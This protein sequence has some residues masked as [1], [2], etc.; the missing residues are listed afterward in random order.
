MSLKQKINPIK[1]KQWF[2][3]LPIAWKITGWYSIFLFLMLILLANFTINFISVLDTAETSADLKKKT[4]EAAAEVDTFSSLQDNY[5]FILYEESGLFQRGSFPIDFPIHAPLSINEISTITVKGKDFYYT[6]H[7]L[8]NTSKNG[9]V[10]G[11]TPV[12]QVYKRNNSIILAFFAGGFLFIITVTLGGYLLIHRGLKPVRSV[13]Q[14]AA[15]ISVSHDLSKRIEISEGGNDEIF[16]LRKTFNSMLD[17]LEG[18]AKRERQF[19]SNVS[20]EL[21]TPITVIQAESEYGKDYI[22][23]IE[24]AKESFENIYEQSKF[25]TSIV[26]QLL[27]L[28]RLDTLQEIETETI[29]L[30]LLLKDTLEG[31]DLLLTPIP[32]Q[33]STTI[34][35]E[36]MIKG[37]TL[38]L[39]R[40]LTNLMDNAMK[41][42]ATKISI[43]LTKTDSMAILS[44]T[45]NGEGIENKDLE[46]IWNRLYQSEHSR[47]KSTNSGLGLGLS[48]VKHIIKLHNGSV[49]VRSTPNI[50]TTFEV[51]LPI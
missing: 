17:S 43:G 38:L 46:N 49:N 51:I 47:N 6:D 33:V 27:D 11:I 31:Y 20:H 44:I 34:D 12:P 42:G 19:S 24:E 21:R 2:E 7:P 14:I 45:D 28:S 9:W 29:N 22:T 40:A 36:V 1:I 10:R 39:Q 23:S 30:S 32:I 5:Y 26:T 48:F 18:C 13:N 16:Q 35:E 8:I 3:S 15:D 4:M 50:A 37:N 25:M 41:F